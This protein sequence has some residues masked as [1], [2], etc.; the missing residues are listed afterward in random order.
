MP[1]P[2]REFARLA[3][4]GGLGVVSTAQAHGRSADESPLE[5]FWAD[6]EKGPAEATRAIL[7]LSDQPTAVGFLKEQLKPL[8]IDADFVKTLI[9]L[10]GS[11]DEGE[12]K[13][14]FEELEYFD[15]RLAIPL[16]TLMD[17]VT[18]YPARSRLVE[19]LSGREAESLKGK[20]IELR[21]L[22]GGEGFNFFAQ[23]FG[24][25]WAEHRVSELNAKGWGNPKKKWTRAVRAIVLLEHIATP[26]ALA[27]LKDMAQ[28]DPDAQPTRQAKESLAKLADGER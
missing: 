23:N 14:A 26:D 25:W 6:L 7:K 24:S 19:V 13:T 3:L 16:E 11:E 22:R 27:I 28:G 4:L 12:W 1:I 18:E 2:R 20:K 10:L 17:D 15:P 5:P 21:P 8:K 9:Q